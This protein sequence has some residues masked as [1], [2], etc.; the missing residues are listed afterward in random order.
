MLT[1]EREKKGRIC[2]ADE[3]KNGVGKKENICR[4]KI[5]FVEEEKNEKKNIWGGKFFY[6]E[7]KYL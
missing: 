5:F 6:G 1:M 3:M 2:S 7:K 4:R